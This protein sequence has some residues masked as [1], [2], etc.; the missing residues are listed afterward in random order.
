MVT[1]MLQLRALRG[2][3]YGSE[4][5]PQYKARRINGSSR[6]TSESRA[7]QRSQSIRPVIFPADLGRFGAR[8]IDWASQYYRL[9]THRRMRNARMNPSFDVGVTALSELQAHLAARKGISPISHI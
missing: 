9:V 2:E 3:G 5:P 6:R 7:G 1:V 4:H 8:R